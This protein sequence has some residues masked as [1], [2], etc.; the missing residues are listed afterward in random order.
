MERAPAGS[1]HFA[2]R[3]GFGRGGVGLSGGSVCRFRGRP[4]PAPL[5]SLASEGS[6]ASIRLHERYGF[7][8]VG[9]LKEVGRKFDR[10]LDV[11]LLQR[12]L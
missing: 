5:R 12:I 7:E 8:V 9:R 4:P 6:E 1:A 2:G 11:Y 10:L 3:I